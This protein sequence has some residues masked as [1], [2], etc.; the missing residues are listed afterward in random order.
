MAALPENSQAPDIT[1]SN[2]DGEQVRL[3]DE[4]KT[5][6]VLLTFF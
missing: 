6:P 2:A 3:I 5:G 1:L 4:L